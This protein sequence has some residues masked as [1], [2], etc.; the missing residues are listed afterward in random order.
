MQ[1]L[2]SSLCDLADTL[3]AQRLAEV[4]G[5]GRV[6]IQGGIRPANRF[7]IEMEDPVLKRSIRHAYDVVEMPVLG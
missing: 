5:V 1:S 4:G 2:S 6:S 7:E 3:M